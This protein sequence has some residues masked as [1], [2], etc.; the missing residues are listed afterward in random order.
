MGII[1]NGNIPAFEQNYIGLFSG[2][3]D[4]SGN[5]TIADTNMQKQ[6][7]MKKRPILSLLQVDITDTKIKLKFKQSHYNTSETPQ[8]KYILIK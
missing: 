5:I 1:E 7:M 3:M 4:G 6:Y 8:N 2:D